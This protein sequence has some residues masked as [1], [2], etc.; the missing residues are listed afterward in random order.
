MIINTGARTDIPAFFSEWLCNRL[1]A[2]FVCVRN[3]YYPEQ[4]TRYQLKADVVDCILF[5]TKNPR[6]LLPHL[7]KLE[8]FGVY[9]FVTITPYGADVE[10][11]VPPVNQVIA[12]F[13]KLSV[14]LGREKV[15]WRYDPIY[16]SRFW[17]ID[18][19]LKVFADMAKRLSG[20]TEECVISFIDLYEKT[21]RNFPEARE[22]SASEQIELAKGLAKIGDTYHIAIKTCA[23]T[24]DL[25]AYGIRQAGCIT[26]S[27]LE[28]ACGI[29]LKSMPYKPSRPSC[30]CCIPSHDIGAYNTCPHGC[31][32]CY[33]NENQKLVEK[34]I[35]QH[36][37]HS[38]LLIGEL[39][40][41]D[42]VRDARQESYRDA[43]LVLF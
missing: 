9:F 39:T 8:N 6:P 38:P 10:P 25:R 23:E 33:A 26:K 21:K 28:K 22:L 24:Q 34:N 4:V 31:H 11:Q 17:T 19:H 16:L 43:Q 1:Q 35:K 30:G 14:A 41:A 7:Q 37:P 42:I 32:Y 27:V 15:C 20:Y 29:T 3:P 36:N 40:E 5:C 2:G 13:Q 18:R 12:D